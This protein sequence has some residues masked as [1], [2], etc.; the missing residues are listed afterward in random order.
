MSH[1]TIGVATASV[2]NVTI[3]G[4]AG[5]SKNDSIAPG[6]RKVHLLNGTLIKN[7][8]NSV[9]TQIFKL[10]N[11]GDIEIN[12]NSEETVIADSNGASVTLDGS[13]DVYIGSGDEKLSIA[14]KKAEDI[15]ASK[16]IVLS[17]VEINIILIVSRLK[18]S[19]IIIGVCRLS[20]AGI[21]IR[22][23]TIN[24]DGNCR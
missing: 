21:P 24:S 10:A 23:S 20:R 13:Y 3:S 1:A 5:T 14:I 15:L 4:K 19:I 8:Q 12:S 7:N 2:D 11:A 17:D 16:G 6:I 22:H 9:A 18:N